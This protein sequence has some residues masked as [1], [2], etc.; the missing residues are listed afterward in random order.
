MEHGNPVF[1]KQFFHL[2]R[3]E[4][5]VVSGHKKRRGDTGATPCDVFDVSGIQ[6]VRIGMIDHIS[7]DADEV[8][9]KTFDRI[10]QA[11]VVFSKGF[12]VQVG[13][14]DKRNGTI[15]FTAFYF[16]FCYF[17]DIVLSDVSHGKI[18]RKKCDQQEKKDASFLFFHKKVKSLPVFF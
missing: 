1:G 4:A 15:N 13:N 17:N 7:R 14:L 10:K 2:V 11:G 9:V 6:A 18:H 3:P 5:F 12:L 8:R 16:I